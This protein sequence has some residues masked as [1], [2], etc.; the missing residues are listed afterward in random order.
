MSVT[1]PLSD[2]IASLDLDTILVEQQTALAL[3]D[4]DTVIHAGPILESPSWDAENRTLSVSC[5]GGWSLF[6]WRLVLDSLL[7]SREIDG[8]LLIDEDNPGAEWTVAYQGTAGDI[9]RSLIQLAQRWGD[10]PVDA[11]AHRKI[12]DPVG[13]TVG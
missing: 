8:E 11:G 10:L 2:D 13:A 3:L 6:E 9:A 7:E 1:I 4:G 12:V 5:G